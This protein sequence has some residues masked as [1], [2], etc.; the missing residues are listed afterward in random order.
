MAVIRPG[1]CGRRVRRV[2]YRP[3]ACMALVSHVG[4]ET[5]AM[6][7]NVWR[8]ISR[9]SRMYSRATGDSRKQARIL[10]LIQRAAASACIDPDTTLPGSAGL[11]RRGRAGWIA[12]DMDALNHRRP[13]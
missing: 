2:V 8:I 11:G 1:T 6:K 9:L 7:R 13:L 12:L 4:V 10:T 5:K 3:T